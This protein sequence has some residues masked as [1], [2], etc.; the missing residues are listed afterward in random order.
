MLMV[1]AIMLSVISICCLSSKETSSRLLTG[2]TA[3]IGFWDLLV[4]KLA[5]FLPNTL[6]CCMANLLPSKER[7][8]SKNQR[9]PRLMQR[10]QHQ[11]K[12]PLIWQPSQNLC[13]CFLSSFLSS[14]PFIVFFPLFILYSFLPSSLLF[15]AKKTLSPTPSFIFELM[16]AK[17]LVHSH[18][19]Q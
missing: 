6:N 9:R 5:G 2:L 10:Q 14:F 18:Q 13:L 12:Q 15:S 16:K 1:F 3:V 17:T 7:T 4:K 11:P 8:K 19:E